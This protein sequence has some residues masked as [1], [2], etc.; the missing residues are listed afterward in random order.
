MLDPKLEKKIE[1]L[2]ER[3]RL[4]L[5][6]ATV[7]RELGSSRAIVRKALREL[8]EREVVAYRSGRYFFLR[9]SDQSDQPGLDEEPAALGGCDL[10]RRVCAFHADAVHAVESSN[11]EFDPDDERLAQQ[12]HDPFDWKALAE[13]REVQVLRHKLPDSIRRSVSSG[14]GSRV[15]LCGPMHLMREQKRGKE[16]WVWRPVFL[17]HAK[18]RWSQDG[19]GFTID[20]EVEV[21]LAWLD[22]FFA[23]GEEGER[24][25]F[26]I[27]TGL[28]H[29]HQTGSFHAREVRDFSTCWDALRRIDHLFDWKR[30]RS[31]AVREPEH[32]L[33][34]IDVE[35]VYPHVLIF[36][37]EL[38]KFAKGLI[39]ELRQIA[40]APDTAIESS[41]LTALL[42][43]GPDQSAESRPNELVRV[44]ASTLNARQ[45]RVAE[46]ALS[47]PLTVVQGPPG[48]G[49]STV[50]RSALLSVGVNGQSAIFS[51][52]NHR[53]IDAVL[54]GWKDLPEG[55]RIIAD[56]RPSEQGA[57]W[58][59]QLQN[60]L[61]ASSPSDDF[62]LDQFR[63]EVKGLN[64][65]E[66]DGFRGLRELFEQS[67]ALADM[68]ASANHL[69]AEF[70][71]RS[72]DIEIALK[73]VSDAGLTLLASWSS[74]TGR[75]RWLWHPWRSLTARKLLPKE[76]R[77]DLGALAVHLQFEQVQREIAA[78]E[79]VVRELGSSESWVD[80]VQTATDARRERTQDAVP[81]LRRAWARGLGAEA[82]SKL[83]EIQRQ[84]HQTAARRR[85]RAMSERQHVRDLLPGMPLWAIT[86]LSASRAVPFVPGLFDLA[87]IDEAG[88][89]TPA[90]ALP[91]L[92]RARRALIVG[93]PQQLRPISRLGAQKEDMLRQKHGLDSTE[94]TRLLYSGR[95][96]YELAADA[97]VEREGS[98]Q[99]LREHYRCHPGIAQYFSQ[100]FYGDELLIRTIGRKKG[101]LG[102]TWT[103][104]PGGS[105]T[106]GS[107][108]WHPLQ[109]GAIVEEL[110]ALQTR[111]FDGTV[112]VVTP[113]REHAK[114]IRDRAHQVLGTRQLKK[115]DF[116]SETADKFQ[117]G[118]KDV[119]L[120]GLIG[121]GGG[122]RET[123]SFYSSDENRFNVAVSRA[124]LHLHIFGDSS[125][126]RR[127]GVQALE[128]LVDAAKGEPKIEEESFR[129][130]LVGPIWEPRL[131]EAFQAAGLD[132]RQQYPALGYYLDFAL[133]DQEGQKINIEV[134]GETYHRDRDGNL[135]EEDVRRDLAL[136]A[137]GW[138]VKRF[139]VYE[140]R[141]D[142]DCCVQQVAALVARS[143][144]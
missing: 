37:E 60:A 73:S 13:G 24:H 107:S 50:V 100:Q 7:A 58:S 61:R 89:C 127:S 3:S 140:L 4:G 136:R 30:D 85:M 28:L 141:E 68:L 62:C 144:V 106:V 101:G 1:Q 44:E 65:S 93:D 77:S 54:D 9:P 21:N 41:A 70:T 32:K 122:S 114:R 118:E 112:G 16:K 79:L 96:A 142:M 88:Q 126:A 128:N 38:S 57:R 17:V 49:K 29:Q 135:C 75:L 132:Y 63:Q 113:F 53:A 90:T 95:S 105:Q 10:I 123:P 115:W 119:V 103:E 109:V 81:R 2:L 59:H 27:Q 5:A 111:E 47:E 46:C 8:L 55:D 67:N 36:R 91:M 134:D 110:Q 26:L 104:V 124:R 99:L 84:G 133:F 120:F 125:W 6:E 131:A 82:S 108:R 64:Q 76:V 22:R 18:E 92:F 74:D 98:V 94:T 129:A 45:S 15:T 39:V 138:I 12:L 87:I 56:L 31:L 117:G 51:S 72:D 116:V 52:V 14:A 48:T 102:L 33:E 130:D 34:E 86:S 66:A 42:P 78:I 121:G 23:D 35:G 19:V 97:L 25:A 80:R 143:S 69:R 43:L 71:P 137:D 20:G 83:A 11:L 139:W 40:E